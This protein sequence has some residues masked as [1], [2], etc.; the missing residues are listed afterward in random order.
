MC[1]NVDLD[2]NV[3]ITLRIEPLKNNYFKCLSKFLVHLN[4]YFL[5]SFTLSYIS[6]K[7]ISY[8]DRI[9]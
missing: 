3:F 8:Y 9:S 6:R 5:L 4:L 2:V 7:L 1:I